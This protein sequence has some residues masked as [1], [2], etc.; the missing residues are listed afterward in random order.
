MLHSTVLEKDVGSFQTLVV[1]NCPLFVLAQTESFKLCLL[2]SVFIPSTKNPSRIR[3]PFIRTVSKAN[4][5][6]ASFPPK[7]DKTK[8]FSETEEKF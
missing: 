3:D 8:S 6:E 2:T 5:E 4:H 1:L 7:S